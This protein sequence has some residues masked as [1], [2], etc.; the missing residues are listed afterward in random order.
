S[1]T[2]SASSRTIVRPATVWPAAWSSSTIA[3]PLVSVASVRVSLTVTTKHRT[4]RGA[5]ALCSASAACGTPVIL[6]PTACYHPAMRSRH[7]A[8][9][10]CLRVF[11]ACL[12]VAVA[13]ASGSKE[14]FTLDRDAARWVEQTQK[15]LTVD[16][17]IGQVIVPSLDSTYLSSD[18]D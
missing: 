10:S 8:W 13:A 1:R 17:K 5:S 2:S 12:F 11:V 7:D 16:E 15:T 14:P 6:P 18:T 4:D 3:F 9:S